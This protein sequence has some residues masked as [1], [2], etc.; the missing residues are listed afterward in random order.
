MI[1]KVHFFILILPLHFSATVW[2][3]DKGVLFKVGT[4]ILDYSGHSYTNLEKELIESKQA[5]ENQEELLKGIE[6]YESFKK[7]FETSNNNIGFSVYDIFWAGCKGSL[8]YH[9]KLNESK[10]ETMDTVKVSHDPRRRD[11]MVI[12]DEQNTVMRDQMPRPMFQKAIDIEPI[13]RFSLSSNHDN[14]P[15]ELG[16]LYEDSYQR[17]GGTLEKGVYSIKYLVTKTPS[18]KLEVLFEGDVAQ[19]WNHNGRAQKYSYKLNCVGPSIDE[20]K[21]LSQNEST[22]IDDLKRKVFED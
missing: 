22:T 9:N 14:P 11:I 2:S 5:L 21:Q 6:F 3:E 17:S 4:K 16:K 15:L 20:L 7:H 19:L 13:S 10:N 12:K 8:L 18:N 1:N